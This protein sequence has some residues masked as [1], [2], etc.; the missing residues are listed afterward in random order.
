MRSL[1]LLSISFLAAIALNA[2]AAASDDVFVVVRVPTMAEA[3]RATAAKARAQTAGR[4][5]AMDILLRRLTPEED[6]AYLPMLAEAGEISAADP[7]GLPHAQNDADA[8]DPYAADQVADT[9]YGA[10]G[11]ARTPI[12]LTDRELEQLEAGFEVFGEKSSARSYRALITY[13]FKP[14]EVRRLLKQAGIPYSEAQ[15]RTALVLP[16]LE[17]DQSVYLWEERN[18]WMAAWKSR[19][20]TQELTPMIAPLGDLEDSARI[21][22]REALALDQAALEAMAK[23]YDVSQIIIAHARL[24]QSNGEDRLSVRLINGYRDIGK[25]DLDAAAGLDDDGAI[26]DLSNADGLNGD[27]DAAEPS[28]SARSPSA[29]SIDGVQ[30]ITSEVGDVLASAVAAEPSGNFLVLAENVIDKSITKYAAGWKERTLIDHASESVLAVSVFFDNLGD[31]SRIRSALIASPLVGAA[32]ISAMS[33]RGAEMSVRVFGDPSRLQVSMENQG[34]VFWSETGERWFIATPRAANRLRGQRF[35]RQSVRV[36]P[37]VDN[38]SA[39][40]SYVD[41]VYPASVDYA[42]SAAPRDRP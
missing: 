34:V 24:K 14:D 7:S 17:T 13:R 16:V 1:I 32:Q 2:P 39:R 8:F 41:R 18:P 4:R 12:T 10:N 9:A 22:A 21:T 30:D 6:W 19:P 42:P 5:R 26:D 29:Y 20:F 40:D 36:P 23:Q 37:D 35:L 15:M 11:P 27:F 33:R 38:G 3:E 28:F 31:W 25:G